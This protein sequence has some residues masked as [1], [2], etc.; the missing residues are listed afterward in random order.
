MGATLDYTNTKFGYTLTDRATWWSKIASWTNLSVPI[1]LKSV[2]ENDTSGILINPYSFILVNSTRH[3]NVNQQLAEKF[4][5]F[6]LSDYGLNKVA[7][8]LAFG[9]S[10]FNI[11]WNNTSSYSVTHSETTDIDWWNNKVVELGMNT[12]V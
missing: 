3:P 2:C 1:N 11:C 10:L 9:H 6:C 7:S 5:A 8:Y 4:V 12:L